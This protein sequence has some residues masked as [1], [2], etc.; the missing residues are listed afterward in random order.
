MVILLCHYIPNDIAC[1]KRT[2]LTDLNFAFVQKLTGPYHKKDII[3][4]SV[5]TYRRA[6]IG[7]CIAKLESYIYL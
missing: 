1:Q 6:E 2:N 3:T 5:S 4:S 7:Q